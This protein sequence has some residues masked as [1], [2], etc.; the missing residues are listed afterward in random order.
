MSFHPARTRITAR[1]N[2]RLG[3]MVTAAAIGMLLVCSMAYSAPKKKSVVAMFEFAV[4][5]RHLPFFVAKHKGYYKEQG[6]EV[7]FIPGSGQGVTLNTVGAG[8]A[9]FGVGDSLLLAQ[10]IQS[11]VAVKSVMV[12]SDKHP[13]GFVSWT[14]DN[15][16]T[17]KNYEGKTISHAIGGGF[18]DLLRVAMEINKADYGKVKILDVAPAVTQ[19]LFLDGKVDLSSSTY[20]TYVFVEAKAGPGR[21]RFLMLA[22]HGLN[23]YGYLV[24]AR[25]ALLQ[26]DPDMV[27]AFVSATVKGMRDAL[28]NPDEAAGILVKYHPNLNLAF[29]KVQAARWAEL[30]KDAKEL[31]RVV[32]SKMEE[33][34]RLSARVL[35]LTSSIKPDELYTNEFL[36]R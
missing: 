19:G 36:P 26:D 18:K 7:E 35:G 5:G 9:E 32:P 33:T 2:S 25:T 34:M 23:I 30:N 6:L 10:A 12:L 28:R 21:T 8:K 16:A 20:E 29:T 24:Y 13:A 11:K 31:G 1:S 27:R 3:M 22:D 14:K 17:L 4:N 15:I